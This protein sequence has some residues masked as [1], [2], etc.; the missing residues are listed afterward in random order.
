VVTPVKDG[1]KFGGAGRIGR[2]IGCLACYTGKANRPARERSIMATHNKTVPHY[3]E[4]LNNIAS[5]ER[6]AGVFL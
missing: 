1:N 5:G 3:L 2:D 4:L 6:H